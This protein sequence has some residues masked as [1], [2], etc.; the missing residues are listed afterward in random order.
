[1]GSAANNNELRI[2]SKLS[3]SSADLRQ[4]IM[5]RSPISSQKMGAEFA[6]VL[7][8]SAA[9]LEPATPAHKDDLG[10]FHTV[11]TRL[12]PVIPR[13][14]RG[15]PRQAHGCPVQR[16]GVSGKAPPQP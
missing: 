15:W 16:I 4:G 1:M 12:I 8:S 5:L 13:G 2:Q 3:N 10:H 9:H 14:L 6:G 11:I 7:L